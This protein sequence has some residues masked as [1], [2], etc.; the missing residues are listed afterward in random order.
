VSVAE[1]EACLAR[2]YTDESFRRLYRHD[3]DEALGGYLLAPEE[4]QA[5]EELDNDRLEF[6]ASSLRAKRR[7][8][9]E[10]AYPGLFALQ[11]PAVAT[12]YDRYHA[13]YPLRPNGAS[14]DEVLQFGAFIAET[15]R[16][17]DPRTAELV[18]FEHLLQELRL[19]TPAGGPLY[20]TPAA[21]TSLDDRLRLRTGAR[22]ECFEYPVS[23]I[24]HALATGTGPPTEPEEEILICAPATGDGEPSVLRVSGPTALLVELCDGARTV[25]DVI[26]A[27]ERHYG[28]DGLAGGIGGAIDQLLTRGVL[29]HMDGNEHA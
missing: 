19:R 23:A 27:V 9:L 7:K 4:R 2:L 18:R 14:S 5:I 12:F 28:D 20:P 16:I 3:T 1:M 11:E 15:M 29:E 21:P 22:L 24:E 17:T 26:T 8:R 25:R 13:L 10:R 6:F